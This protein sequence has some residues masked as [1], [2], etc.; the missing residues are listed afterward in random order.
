M[1]LLTKT[2]VFN[3]PY[4]MAVFL[5]SFLGLKSSNG[6]NLHSKIGPTQRLDIVE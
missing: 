2:C 1:I 3:S 6:I 4:L 5:I